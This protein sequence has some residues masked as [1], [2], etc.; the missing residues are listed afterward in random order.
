MSLSMRS[1][2]FIA[3][4][5]PSKRWY[6]TKDCVKLAMGDSV[7]VLNQA[8][9]CP[10]RLAASAAPWHF[11]FAPSLPPRFAENFA[12]VMKT[13]RNSLTHS[14]EHPSPSIILPS[15]HS[16][17]GLTSLSPQHGAQDVVVFSVDPDEV[18]VAADVVLVV[19]VSDEL[20]S[21]VAPALMSE[22]TEGSDVAS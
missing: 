17:G 4:M 8:R 13:R 20:A 1:A 18:V 22:V 7:D 15:S 16:S 19:L 11:W 12:L 6:G 9:Y 2:Q 14:D 21:T 3:T 10:G 5:A